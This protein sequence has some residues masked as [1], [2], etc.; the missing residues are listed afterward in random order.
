MHN[1]YKAPYL[2][3]GADELT[4]IAGDCLA[5]AQIFGVASVER[6]LRLVSSS[7]GDFEIST[8]P[9]S[10]LGIITCK[11][12]NLPVL[13]D[14]HEWL[15]KRLVT[16]PP[17]PK[18]V[19]G[20]MSEAVLK[21]FAT[22]RA[23][24]LAG[25]FAAAF[26][27]ASRELALVRQAHERLENSFQAMEAV[28]FESGLQP[29]ELAFANE[30]ARSRESLEVPDQG[31][32]QLLPVSS[33]GLVALALH[34]AGNSGSAPGG[35]RVTLEA[36]EEKT[37]IAIWNLSGERFEPGWSMLMLP[38]GIG[39]LKRT[40]LLRVYG[41]EQDGSVPML[42][43]GDRMPIAK[44]QVSDVATG[45]PVLGRALALQA[46][47]GLANVRPGLT[48]NCWLP[49]GRDERFVEAQY[50][51][52]A[53]ALAQVTM[54]S[55]APT[56]ARSFKI[57]D[58]I[59]KKKTISCHPITRQISIAGLDGVL[60][61]GTVRVSAEISLENPKA[62]DVEFG[63][64]AAPTVEAAKGLLERSAKAE[65]K[66]PVSA[67]VRVRGGQASQINLYIDDA[68]EKHSL[69]LATRIADG[70]PDTFAASHFSKLRYWL[71]QDLLTLP[72]ESVEGRLRSEAVAERKIGVGPVKSE[73]VLD[74][75]E[76]HS[77]TVSVQSASMLWPEQGEFDTEDQPQNESEVDALNQ[78]SAADL[79]AAEPVR[80]ESLVSS[81][82]SAPADDPVGS[83]SAMDPMKSEPAADLA[84]TD[85]DVD[86][87]YDSAVDQDSSAAADSN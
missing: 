81:R 40:L 34:L 12:A 49:L 57:V 7:G 20:E 77:E 14:V 66:V 16:R 71:K 28:L 45:Q 63:M 50:N 9:T 44:Y 60:P 35:L 79:P 10:C 85:S 67:W 33:R 1:L 83:E 17:A 72:S 76:S 15:T 73:P 82:Q 24:A 13:Q 36:L 47:V 43:L 61:E 6:T 48:E 25:E 64:A 8:P 37:L 46:W 41:V 42:S 84:S 54:L 39:G 80:D 27:S 3:I 18:L 68:A 23:L 74:P 26:A 62:N 69:A 56:P 75:L 86:I 22:E 29:F 70:K 51:I 58:Y 4:S 21:E 31:I 2:L 32:Q 38:E 19:A 59:P 55:A 65:L 87:E 78:D 52:S 30:P 5:G 53:E 11:E